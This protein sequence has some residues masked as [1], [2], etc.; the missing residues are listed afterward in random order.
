MSA[1][2]R[3]AGRDPP[4]P[5]DDQLGHEVVV[6]A[7]RP[8][9]EVEDGEH[10]LQRVRRRARAAAYDLVVDGEDRLVGVPVHRVGVEVGDV[11]VDAGRVEVLG[12]RRVAEGLDPD[13]DLGRRRVRPQ[14][15]AEDLE[16]ADLPA[17]ELCGIVLEPAHPERG[18]RPRRQRHPGPD[19]DPAARGQPALEALLL[20]ADDLPFAEPLLAVDAADR[21]RPVARLDARR[22]AAAA[23]GRRGT[24]RDGRPGR[25]APGCRARSG[26]S[27]RSPRGRTRPGR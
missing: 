9:R 24:R 4:H 26:G 12:E 22:P 13:P 25:R 14:R 5:V 16:H 3:R 2:R 21:T 19:R 11:D 27:P 8:L 10:Q 7:D 1:S 20:L 15:V 17:L 23:G 18:H 6:V